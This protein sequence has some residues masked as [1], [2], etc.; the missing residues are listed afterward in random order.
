MRAAVLLGL[1]AMAGDA[2]AKTLDHDPA[3]DVAV[4]KAAGFAWSKRAWR[5]NCG[6]PGSDSYQEG[7]IE[8]IGDL[9]RDGWPEALV[10]EGS[11]YCYG[12]TGSAFWLLAGAPGG[13]WKLVLQSVGVPVVLKTRGVAKW[14]D[15]SVGGPGFCF[16]VMRWNG[17]AYARNRFEYEGKRCSPPR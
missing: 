15:I 7:Q 16:A 1:L 14:P 10:T 17:T 13:K 5:S 4:F 6:D 2:G 9:N 11:T 3:V 12:N 8:W